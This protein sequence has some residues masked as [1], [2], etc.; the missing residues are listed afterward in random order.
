MS[1]NRLVHKESEL[2]QRVRT[3]IAD[4]REGSFDQLQLAAKTE[5]RANAD[6]P[7]AWLV[8]TTTRLILCSTHR[9][10]LHWEMRLADVNDIRLVGHSVHVLPN[11]VEK[12]DLVV[13][14]GN[15]A[16]ADQEALVSRLTATLRL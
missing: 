16:V 8:L 2:P 6:T 12:G 14:L 7:Y 11:E 10:G 4:T 5:F 3:W 13:P 1:G 15:L 9:R